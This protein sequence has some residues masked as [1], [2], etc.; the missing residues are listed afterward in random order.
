MNII[1]IKIKINLMFN[2]LMFS[3][4]YDTDKEKHDKQEGRKK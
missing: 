4:G 3:D 1:S 2:V